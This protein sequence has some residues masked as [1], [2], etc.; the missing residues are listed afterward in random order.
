[1]I[2]GFYMFASK[3]YKILISKFEKEQIRQKLR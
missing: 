2:L 3:I 1:M